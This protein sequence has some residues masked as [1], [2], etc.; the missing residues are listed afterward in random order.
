MELIEQEMR[1]VGEFDACVDV[2]RS[3]YSSAIFSPNT[4]NTFVDELTER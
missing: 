1:E 3:K 2:A 4:L